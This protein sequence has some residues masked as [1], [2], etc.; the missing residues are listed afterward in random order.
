[1]L[2]THDQ[3]APQD[4]DGRR[5]REL[6][7]DSERTHLRTPGMVAMSR[8][9]PWRM[10]RDQRLRNHVLAVDQLERAQRLS[11]AMSRGMSQAV[12]SARGSAPSRRAGV[13]DSICERVNGT[14]RDS[15]GFTR[16]TR[17][18]EPT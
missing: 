4:R 17:R 2:A 1:M 18:A 6:T 13:G 10:Q 5:A 7:K 8:G 3:A 15:V 14:R 11:G 9:M 16:L 12:A